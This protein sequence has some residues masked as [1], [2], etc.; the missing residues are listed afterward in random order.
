MRVSTTIFLAFPKQND[1]Q[2]SPVSHAGNS[3]LAEELTLE[4]VSIFEGKNRVIVIEQSE[5]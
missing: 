2:E 3:R 4:F 1:D 5:D